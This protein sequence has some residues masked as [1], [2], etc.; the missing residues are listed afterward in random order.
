MIDLRKAA[1][2]AVILAAPAAIATGCSKGADKSATASPAG[3][4]VAVAS[5]DTRGETAKDEA[6]GPVITPEQLPVIK[7]GLWETSG[8]K[9]DGSKDVDKICHSGKAA[10]AIHMGEA[11]SKLTI[12]RTLLGGYVMDAACGGKGMDMTMHVKATGDF[13]SHYAVD[14][15]ATIKLPGQPAKTE[16]DHKEARWVGACPAGMDVEE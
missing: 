8:T 15:T 5:A 16:S 14:T 12:H 3:S 10:K 6:T 1:V 13:S 4:G 11:C 7:A 2:L 9:A